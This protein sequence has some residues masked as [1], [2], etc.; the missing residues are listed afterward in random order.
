M[1]VEKHP[2]L[3]DARDEAGPF[4]LPFLVNLVDQLGG[5]LVQRTLAVKVCK[6]VVGVS[7]LADDGW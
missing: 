5:P 3:F 6:V 2:E 4:W 7:V 1:L